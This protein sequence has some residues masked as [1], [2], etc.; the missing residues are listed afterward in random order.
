MQDQL[1]RHHII[2]YFGNPETTMIPRESYIAHASGIPANQQTAP[3]MMV[4]FNTAP[5]LYLEDNGYVISK[6]SKPPDATG[7][8]PIFAYQI[9]KAS[10]KA[11]DIPRPLHLK[12]KTAASR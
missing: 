8:G 4:S 12:K 7:N 1:D 3:G 6:E 10:N 2:Q 11:E 9:P 5:V